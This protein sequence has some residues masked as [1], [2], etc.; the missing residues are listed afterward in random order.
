MA[1]EALLAAGGQLEKMARAGQAA[2]LY[3]ELARD[4]AHSPPAAEARQ[5]L[6]RLG[7]PAK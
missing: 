1:A 3:R 4:Y 6:E 7:L 5:R 2:Q